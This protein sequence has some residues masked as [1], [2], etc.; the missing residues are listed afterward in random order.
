MK[1]M[2]LVQLAFISLALS[3]IAI[4]CNDEENANPKEVYSDGIFITNEGNYSSGDGSVSFYS[5]SEDIVYNDIFSAVNNR[6]LGSVVQSLTTYDDKVYIIV[7]ASNKVEIADAGSFKELASITNLDN[8]RYFIGINNSKGY[9]SQWGNNGEIKIIDLLT[10]EISGTID[11]GYG[12]DKMYKYSNYVFVANSGGWG[13]DSTVMLINSNTNLVTDT[14]IVGHNPKD[15]VVDK[16][17]NLWVLC[18]GYIQYDGSWN[19]TFESASELYKID[20][21]NFEVLKKFTISAT[22]HPDHIEISPDGET[23]YYG[24]GFSFGNIFKMNINDNEL[25]LEPMNDKYFYGFNVDWTNGVIFALEA[26]SFT[27]NGTL[28]RYS[29]DGTELGSYEVGVAP[30]GTGLKK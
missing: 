12:P 1:K 16:D 30:N 18:Y 7:N 6:P 21:T 5:N 20:L 19:V 3:I 8:P 23:I 17:Q 24:A 15:L 13:K 22:S 11:V 2:K 14:L 25:P 27:T 9:L 4:S 28:Y 10:N 26:P 29:P